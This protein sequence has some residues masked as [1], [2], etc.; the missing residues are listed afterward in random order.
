[1]SGLRHVLLW[2]KKLKVFTAVHASIDERLFVVDVHSEKRRCFVD[3][4]EICG[5]AASALLAQ[6]ASAAPRLASKI[7][8][9]ICGVPCASD[10]FYSLAML[11]SRG[12]GAVGL[13]NDAMG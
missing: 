1:L 8:S 13:T 9:R 6:K 12:Y 3:R 4:K 7:G 5:K 2:G 10:C 11:G